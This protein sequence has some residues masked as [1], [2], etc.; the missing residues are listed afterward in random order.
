MPTTSVLGSM[1]PA[2]LVAVGFAETDVATTVATMPAITTAAV[3]SRILL[4]APVTAFPL[5]LG[6]PAR[7]SGTRNSLHSLD[8]RL[9]TPAAP[10]RRGPGERPAGRRRE[11]ALDAAEDEI[12]HE[13][14]DDVDHCSRGE[15]HERLEVDRLQVLRHA[16]DLGKPDHREDRGVFH[17]PDEHA[18][19]VRDRD[20]RRLGKDDLDEDAEAAHAER[21]P[22]LALPTRNRFERRA[23]DLRDE[24]AVEKDE[25]DHARLED[26]EV[27]PEEKRPP[28]VDPQ[29]AD[30]RGKAAEHVHV[31]A[32]EPG[33][34]RLAHPAERDDEPDDDGDDDRDGS[35]LERRREPVEVGASIVPREAPVV[36]GRE[37]QSTAAMNCFVRGFTQLLKKPRGPDSAISPSSMKTLKSPIS[38]AKL[39]SW[40]TMTIVIPDSATARITASTSPTSSG[41]R[42]EVGSP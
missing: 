3:T 17:H 9:D 2:A 6:L 13:R 11:N 8:E 15:E 12:Q 33:D 18:P 38:R 20:L 30:E 21:Q 16:H 5:F 36:R 39:S 31:D 19:D 22:R 41:S 14:D 28:E 37:H 27:D 34:G 25:R 40:V 10:R 7:S 24:G 26:G 1:R 32:G 4:L 29:H 35:D 23:V 42:A